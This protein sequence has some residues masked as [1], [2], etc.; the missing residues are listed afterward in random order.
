[1]L[2]FVYIYSPGSWRDMRYPP[3]PLHQT[4]AHG[5]SHLC[6]PQLGVTWFICH[7]GPPIDSSISTELLGGSDTRKL[8]HFECVNEKINTL[9]YCSILHQTGSIHP[10]L[11]ERRR[12]Q[13][14]RGDQSRSGCFTE[15]KPTRK[16]HSIRCIGA[17]S[18]RVDCEFF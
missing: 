7:L 4:F 12:R 18:F 15:Q 1:M 5:N 6:A 11:K 14:Q 16:L 9:E 8:K 3:S 13:I 17:V 2:W 10:L